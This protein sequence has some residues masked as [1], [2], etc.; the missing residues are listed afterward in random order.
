MNFYCV[1]C[2]LSWKQRANSEILKYKKVTDR[3]KR[4][5]YEIDELCNRISSYGKVYFQ[6]SAY[7]TVDWH[8]FLGRRPS[9]K[10]MLSGVTTGRDTDK[11]TPPQI[12]LP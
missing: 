3:S 8:K 12:S 9:N 2:S 10:G 4:N 6:I 5:E 11:Y 7:M 1:Y